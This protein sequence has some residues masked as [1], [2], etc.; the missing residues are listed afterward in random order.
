MKY[1]TLVE[2]IIPMMGDKELNCRELELLYNSKYRNSVNSRQ[3]TN[4]LNSSKKFDKVGF[5]YVQVAFS[6]YKRKVIVWKVKPQFLEV[7]E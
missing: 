7:N 4:I 1:Q 6:K 3:V 2:R 5:D